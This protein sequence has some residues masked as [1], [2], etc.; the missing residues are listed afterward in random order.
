LGTT[1]DAEGRPVLP[2][3]QIADMTCGLM[4]TLGILA[5]LQA[6]ERT[7]R[8]Q[9][10]DASLFDSALALMTVPLA[11]RLAGGPVV[12]ELAGT[13]GFYNVYRCADGRHLSVGAL[14]PKF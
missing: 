10:V 12:N 3:T 9:V 8:G 7:G 14:E 6:R 1:V 4:G 5:A 13:Q 2:V 11:R